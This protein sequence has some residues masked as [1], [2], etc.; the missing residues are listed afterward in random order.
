M[1][2][3]KIIKQNQ[4]EWTAS[5]YFN[6]ER[7]IYVMKYY[8]SKSSKNGT[9][10]KYSTLGSVWLLKLAGRGDDSSSPWMAW[11]LLETENNQ[12]QKE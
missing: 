11:D 3:N 7:Q 10:Q 2:S 8:S 12:K 4:V 9:R 5:I 1:F 6:L